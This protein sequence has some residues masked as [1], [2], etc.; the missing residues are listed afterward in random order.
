MIEGIL[1]PRINS[2]S[3]WLVD[4]HVWKP[5][6]PTKININGVENFFHKRCY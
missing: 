2:V 5:V 4:D 6:N 3:L 1:V